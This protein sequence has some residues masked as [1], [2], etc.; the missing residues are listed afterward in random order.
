MPNSAQLPFGIKLIYILFKSPLRSM[1][2]ISITIGVVAHCQHTCLG[3]WV[4]SQ[5]I[6]ALPLLIT[7]MIIGL[8]SVQTKLKLGLP[9][10][11]ELGK[12]AGSWY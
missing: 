9:N 12:I 3:G 6:W 7:V 2:T 4:V 11:T 10:G 8:V 5:R 1:H